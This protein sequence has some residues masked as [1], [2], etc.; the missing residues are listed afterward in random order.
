MKATGVANGNLTDSDGVAS[1]IGSG[2]GVDGV[3][4]VDTAAGGK[5][6]HDLNTHVVSQMVG[7]REA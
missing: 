5:A 1:D 7:R 3:T 6:L 4:V 2:T